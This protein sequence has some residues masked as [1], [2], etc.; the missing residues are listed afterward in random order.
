MFTEK[1]P[2]RRLDLY[3]LTGNEEI[4]KMIIQCRIHFSTFD[5]DIYQVDLVVKGLGSINCPELL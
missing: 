2:P 3:N 4:F 5:F 1:T